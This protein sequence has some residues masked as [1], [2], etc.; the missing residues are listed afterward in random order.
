MQNVP[1]G[2]GAGFN[3][4][5]STLSSCGVQTYDFNAN[6]PPGVKAPSNPAPHAVQKVSW[7]VAW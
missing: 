1:C 4:A 2:E 5:A 7:A 3:L 6:Q